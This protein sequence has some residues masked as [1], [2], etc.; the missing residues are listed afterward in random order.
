MCSNLIRGQFIKLLHH[1]FAIVALQVIVLWVIPLHIHNHDK[2]KSTES[3]HIAAETEIFLHYILIIPF[4]NTC[5]NLH[6]ND[7]QNYHHCHYNQLQR[8][9]WNH[10]ESS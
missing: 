5:Y 6:Q 8:F 10:E 4:Y 2:G 3:N 1:W 9:S 7:N